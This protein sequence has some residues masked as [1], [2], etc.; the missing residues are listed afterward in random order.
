MKKSLKF[1]ILLFVFTNTTNAGDLMI[2]K[3]Y[4]LI[5]PIYIMGEYKDIGNKMISKETARAFLK[6]VKLAKRNFT[7]FQAEV[8]TGTVIT[9]VKQTNKPWYLYFNSDYYLV[10]LDPDISRGIEVELPLDNSFKGSLDG[11]NSEIFQNMD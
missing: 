11:L 7:A 1:T 9:I 4:K 8:P 3:K 5:K 2:G 6:T 10:T